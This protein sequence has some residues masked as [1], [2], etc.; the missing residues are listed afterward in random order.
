MSVKRVIY[1]VDQ[2]RVP[3]EANNSFKDSAKKLGITPYDAYTK[4]A[5]LLADLSSNDA[6]DKS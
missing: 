2:V 5:E 3:C 4:G 6:K 1:D